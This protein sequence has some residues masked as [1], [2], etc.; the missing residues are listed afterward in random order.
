MCVWEREK[1]T[2]NSSNVLTQIALLL[3]SDGKSEDGPVDPNNYCDFCLGDA[4]ENKKTGTQEEL[5]SCAD[6]GRSGKC[7]HLEMI[8]YN[9]MIDNK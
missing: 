7:Q 4:T 6:C 2:F 1:S 3:V 9:Y 5:I 8:Y